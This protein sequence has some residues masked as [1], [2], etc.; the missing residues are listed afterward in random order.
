MNEFTTPAI[1]PP[2]TSGNLT[3]LVVERASL[4]PMRTM[5]SRPIGEGWQNVTARE[6]EQEIRAAAKGF[7]AA[8]IAPGDH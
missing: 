6:L 1:V 2:A 8:G 3:N 7:I 4:E 5:L